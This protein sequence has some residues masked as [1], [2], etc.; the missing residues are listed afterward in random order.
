MFLF[1]AIMLNSVSTDKENRRCWIWIL[2]H[3]EYIPVINTKFTQSE[4]S[5]LSFH[6]QQGICVMYL[7]LIPTDIV[8]G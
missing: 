1:K 3:Q 7:S 6:I 2:N 8:F 4:Y 5:A